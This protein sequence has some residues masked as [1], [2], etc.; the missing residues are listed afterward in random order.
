MGCKTIPGTIDGLSDVATEA[1]T[2]KGPTLVCNHPFLLL[3]FNPKEDPLMSCDLKEIE[4]K[5][6]GFW[7]FERLGTV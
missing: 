3:C 7:G 5:H 2:F 6:L 4:D 1:R